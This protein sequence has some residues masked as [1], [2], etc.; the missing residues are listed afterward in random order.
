MKD[1]VVVDVEQDADIDYV[2]PI[3]TSSEIAVDIENLALDPSKV[4]PQADPMTLAWQ[5]LQ[6]S[7][8]GLSLQLQSLN[9]RATKEAES[10]EQRFQQLEAN[11]RS[12]HEPVQRQ[13]QVQ[14]TS[15][16]DKSLCGKPQIFDGTNFE[17]FLLL[18]ENYSASHSL[19]SVSKLNVLVSY[20][21]PALTA[22]RAWRASNPSGSYEEL[23]KHLKLLYG[24]EPD[25]LRAK[26]NFRN[27][28][29]RKEQS[30]EEYLES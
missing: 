22:Y 29:R 20:L 25:S 26:V 3:G 17:N 24:A 11:L 21:G 2:Q 15:F 18:I 12:Q 9:Y 8:E 13:P 6:A 5:S 7:I 27:L 19:D 4:V 28:K 1:S 30:F 14:P 10:V 23:V 16:K